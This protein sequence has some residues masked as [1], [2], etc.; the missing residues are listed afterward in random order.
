MER[1]RILRQLFYPLVVD[2]GAC[3]LVISQ[4]ARL[5]RRKTARPYQ[6][7]DFLQGIRQKGL[8]SS[9]I[10]KGWTLVGYSSLGLTLTGLPYFQR[11]LVSMLP[12]ASG[13]A[14]VLVLLWI[15]VLSIVSG[16]WA[17]FLRVWA[18][19]AEFDEGYLWLKASFYGVF[20]ALIPYMLVLPLLI[21]YGTPSWIAWTYAISLGLLGLAVG[22][23]WVRLLRL[24]NELSIHRLF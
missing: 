14:P 5:L 8:E 17:G 2:W 6:L 10:S 22:F 24:A 4:R 18:W 19:V 9:L 7:Q 1:D 3:L 15:I 12:E 16:F 11:I 23:R 21:R 20:H 13:N